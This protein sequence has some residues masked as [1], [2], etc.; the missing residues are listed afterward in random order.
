MK[1]FNMTEK[2]LV[3]ALKRG[4]I[5]WLDYLEAVRKLKEEE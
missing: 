4:W 3:E 2:N 1:T 5:S